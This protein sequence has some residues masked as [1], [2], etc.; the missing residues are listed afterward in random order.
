[1]GCRAQCAALDLGQAEGGIVGR[2]DDVGIAY[3]PDAA[4]DAESVDRGDHRDRAFVDRA[5]GGEATAVGVDQRGEALG[6]LH[7]FD[8]HPGVEATAFGPQDHR[9]SG[10]VVAG[11][12]QDLAEFEPSARRDGVDGRVVDGDRDYPRFDGARRDCHRDPRP[13]PWGAMGTIYLSKHLLG[14]LAQ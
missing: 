10:L 5:E 8:V 1:M 12:G 14:T 9:V 13:L 2:H 11:G 7:F 3:Q 6:P 4:P